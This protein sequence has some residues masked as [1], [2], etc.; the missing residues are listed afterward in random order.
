MLVP[1][2]TAPVV[3]NG[4]RHDYQSPGPIPSNDCPSVSS[5]FGLQSQTSI[6]MSSPNVRPEDGTL[7]SA[8]PSTS[9][10]G[11]RGICVFLN[12]SFGR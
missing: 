12:V 11:R 5:G 3:D 9:S 6:V 8:R 4:A 1:F 2:F 10:T 7:P